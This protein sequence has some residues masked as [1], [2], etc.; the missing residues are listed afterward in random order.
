MLQ[1][2][3][4][5]LLLQMPLACAYFSMAKDCSSE[6]VRSI[7]VDHFG[8]LVR[9]NTGSISY[10]AKKDMIK[11]VRDACCGQTPV[12]YV[13]CED[14]S[15]SC[16]TDT[17]KWPWYSVPVQTTHAENFCCGTSIG[18][19]S[20]G[21]AVATV[22]VYTLLLYTT[23]TWLRKLSRRVRTLSLTAC[24]SGGVAVTLMYN[25]LGSPSVWNG[26]ADVLDCA[27]NAPLL[28]QS[29]LHTCLLLLRRATWE[30]SAW[31]V[32]SCASVLVALVTAYSAYS[33][34]LKKIADQIV[35]LRNNASTVYG[36]QVLLTAQQVTENLQES[37]QIN[38]VLQSQETCLT[39]KVAASFRT[40]FK[41][42]IQLKGDEIKF[43]TL[44]NVLNEISQTCWLLEDEAQILE[45]PKNVYRLLSDVQATKFDVE[46]VSDAIQ[47]IQAMPWKMVE[48]QVELESSNLQDPLTLTL[49]AKMNQVRLK[50]Q[51]FKHNMYT[52]VFRLIM[53]ITCAILFV[54]FADV[55][56]PKLTEDLLNFYGSTDPELVKKLL[57]ARRTCVS[58]MREFPTLP[59]TFVFGM[60]SHI[61]V[62]WHFAPNTTL[63][64]DVV[65][66]WCVVPE[67]MRSYD[68]KQ[69]CFVNQQ[70]QD[71]K[72]CNVHLF[73]DKEADPVSEAVVCIHAGANKSR[74]SRNS[75]W[76]TPL[77]SAVNYASYL[78]L[79]CLVNGGEWQHTPNVLLPPVIPSRYGHL[80]G[81][82]YRRFF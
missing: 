18:A 58:V 74:P 17:I 14:A 40:F 55:E 1:N 68:L 45:L 26:A 50:C 15:V 61:A 67:T 81:A 33:S 36:L 48:G 38:G 34:R 20:W 66:K 19:Y 78:F 76:K 22:L 73:L 53:R 82:C 79:P 3:V 25:L 75:D 52:A 9:E 80:I 8:V 11:D 71:W 60:F 43:E 10:G 56:E 70:P 13:L 41:L 57:V 63:K 47:A 23:Q 42:V 65:L 27:I 72:Q 77:S 12:T 44:K 64:F 49:M 62:R 51:D 2:L 21:Y 31:T 30:C 37:R 24:G 6:R 54:K 35:Q 69:G 16:Q 46:I 39:K 5:M 7:C 59:I 28:V 32:I 29:L 4:C